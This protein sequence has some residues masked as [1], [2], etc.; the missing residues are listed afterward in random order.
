MSRAEIDIVVKTETIGDLD[1]K[2]ALLNDEIK[3]VG[4]NSKEFRKL[5]KEIRGVKAAAD[6]AGKALDNIDVGAI[7]GDVAKVGA[8][9]AGLGL[10]VSSFVGESE[11]MNEVL[12]KTNAVLGLS[13][14]AEGLASLAKLGSAAASSVAASAQ[15]AYTLVIGASTGALKGFRIALASTGVGL[16]IIAIGT[17]VANWEELTESV[18]GSDSTLET[19][20]KRLLFITGPLGQVI[21]LI[22][23]FAESIGGWDQLFDAAI[24]AVT[25]FF[26]ELG[27]LF[28]GQFWANV[29]EKTRAALKESQ[30]AE[31]REIEIGNRKK[32]ALY[33]EWNIK[34]IKA[35]DR[36]KEE[37]YLVEKKAI[38]DRLLL[39]KLEFGISSDEYKQYYLDL[40]NLNKA[41]NKYLA[42]QDEKAAKERLKED[43][44]A[45]IRRKFIEDNVKAI[46]K[47]YK[48]AF[49]SRRDL[50][51]QDIKNVNE[52][53]FALEAVGVVIKDLGNISPEG[54]EDAYSGL[55]DRHSIES[56]VLEIET[57]IINHQKK[58]VNISDESS[59][60]EIAN[61]KKVRD[62]IKLL[63]DQKI[64][65][66]IDGLK[67]E[68]EALKE[69]FELNKATITEGNE[70]TLSQHT[71]FIR[72]KEEEAQLLKEI[73][74]LELDLIENS[75][76]LSEASITAGEARIENLTAL[77]EK[78][79]EINE[80]LQEGFAVLGA[81]IDLNNQKI[82][83]MAANYGNLS[84]AI[85]KRYDDEVIAAGENAEKIITINANRDVAL[86][87]AEREFDAK[88]NALKIKNAKVQF[89][90]DIGS[91]ISKTALAIINQYATLPLPAAIPASILVAGVGGIQI[92]AAKKA[93]DAA[94]AG[95]SSVSSPS[96]GGGDR[97]T[98]FAEGGYVEGPGSPTSDSINARLS[99]GEFVV[100]AAATS[101]NRALLENIN[102]SGSNE[103]NLEEILMKIEKRLSIIPKAYVVSSDIKQGLESDEYLERRAQLTT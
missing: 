42:S 66:K 23:K 93:M 55:L 39:A 57:L 51:E 17:L 78:V 21:L 15:A 22:D 16:I 36:S 91:I 75:I 84:K 79:K 83:L 41:Y 61:A 71:E 12:Q 60:L 67:Q 87:N 73:A 53:K 9:I 74:Q 62:E 58:L 76:V 96:V 50:T 88:T 101:A 102:A 4:I 63:E 65:I 103:S 14:A 52:L 24:G 56:K 5:S 80:V 11:E 34:F 98:Q 90:L 100:N 29:G 26:E 40:L 33:D 97:R 64:N 43:K 8:G 45:E 95:A 85:N 18:E 77:E 3:D 7:V 68:Q 54:K 86:G 81:V 1:Q 10:V 89:A 30:D 49:D 20:G 94:I 28:S 70:V 35:L 46:Q 27:N 99:N 59:D 19:W 25:A 6:K 69:S 37:I 72:I 82:A 44:T 38:E 31:A 47:I 13:V 92:A 32:Q 2:L 48:K